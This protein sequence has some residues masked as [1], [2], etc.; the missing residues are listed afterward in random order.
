MPRLSYMPPEAHAR[1][2]NAPATHCDRVFRPTSTPI[3]L[4]AT[5][6]QRSRQ[7]C[8]VRHFDPAN[9]QFRRHVTSRPLSPYARGE[10]TT[11]EDTQGGRHEQ[12]GH[13]EDA[14][15]SEGDES[16]PDGEDAL[17]TY[18]AG[19]GHRSPPPPNT[20]PNRQAMRERA[21]GKP[22]WAQGGATL[23]FTRPSIALGRSRVDNS[24]P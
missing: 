5:R 20:H 24:Y 2:L 23:D 14:K 16:T 11:H 21:R 1:S 4:V 22:C 6:P 7:R 19:R 10:S 17:R 12:A 3:L 13:R 8:S 18:F 15:K 9:A